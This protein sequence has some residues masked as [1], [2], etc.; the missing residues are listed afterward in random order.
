M[1]KIHIA[2]MYV[3]NTIQDCNSSFSNDQLI[4]EGHVNLV[5]IFNSVSSSHV[6]NLIT[7]I[8]QS[9]FILT[10]LLESSY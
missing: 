5:V 7:L 10:V 3:F 4:C 8:M 2:R 9:L 1:Y 6:A